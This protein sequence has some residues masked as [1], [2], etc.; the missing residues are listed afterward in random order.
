MKEYEAPKLVVC[1]FMEEDVI[2]ASS[3]VLTN[4]DDIGDWND[5]WFDYL[6]GDA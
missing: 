4:Y 2:T 1:A 5:D 6:G 3:N